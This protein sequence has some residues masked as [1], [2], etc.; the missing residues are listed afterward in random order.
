M[1]RNIGTFN[2]P[3]NFE[4]TKLG[5]I[6]ARS[7]TGLKSELTDSSLPF[8]YLGMLVSVTDDT[9]ENNGLYMLTSADATQAASWSKIDSSGSGVQSVAYTQASGELVITLADA[10]NTEL[11][12][13]IN[14]GTLFEISNNGASNY[15]IN[16]NAD[17]EGGAAANVNPTIYVNRGETYTF[18]RV[19]AGHPFEIRD[20]NDNPITVG[21]KAGVNPVNGVNAELVWQIPHDADNTYKYICTLHPG[22][23]GEIKVGGI[24]GTSG[25]SGTSGGSGTSGSSGS[26]GLSGVDGAKGAKGD[27]GAAGLQGP[28]GA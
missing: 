15:S 22:M 11:K 18:R 17:Y 14:S 28:P 21:I 8:A 16:D 13:T 24:D 1:A 23:V 26:S 4:V 12:A 2:F 27:T 7:Q 5:P 10:N 19:M 20:V 3:A 6:D 9:A 25:S